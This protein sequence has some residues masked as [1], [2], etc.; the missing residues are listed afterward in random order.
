MRFIEI[1]NST[2]A[3]SRRYF[4]CLAGRLAGGTGKDTCGERREDK[5]K[6]VALVPE[7]AVHD[8]FAET[9]PIAGKRL[10]FGRAATR[11]RNGGYRKLRF[12]DAKKAHLSPKCGEDVFNEMLREERFWRY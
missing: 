8:L 2:L 3:S 4:E 10:L 5:K 6:M 9:P 11:K 12:I 7:S 1:R